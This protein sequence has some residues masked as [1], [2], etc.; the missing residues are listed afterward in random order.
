[1]DFP[2]PLPIIAYLMLILGGCGVSAEI[3][4]K[5]EWPADRSADSKLMI[6]VVKVTEEGD[7]LFGLKRSP[8]LVDNVPDPVTVHG[9]I[10]KQRSELDRKTVTVLLPKLE[11]NN[12]KA[13]QFAVLG[14]VGNTTC[15]CIK[16]IPSADTDISEISCP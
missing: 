15:I 8:S 9:I 4:L 13:Q 1:M 14:I 10:V 11:L 2:H 7:G 3:T 16:P 6:E 12:I 5:W